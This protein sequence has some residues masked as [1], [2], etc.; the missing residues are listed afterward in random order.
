MCAYRS[1]SG[2]MKLAK[3]FTNLRLTEEQLKRLKAISEKTGAPVSALI[4]KAIG[5]YLKKVGRA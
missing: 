4:R 3:K 5:E 2:T 1:T